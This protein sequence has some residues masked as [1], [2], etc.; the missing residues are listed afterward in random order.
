[1]GDSLDQRGAPQR[2]N[3][4]IEEIRHI[5]RLAESGYGKNVILNMTLEED[6]DPSVINGQLA[7]EG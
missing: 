2:S 6:F 5:S 4:T 1:M 7:C 3:E